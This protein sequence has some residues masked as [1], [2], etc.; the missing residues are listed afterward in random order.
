LS[1]VNSLPAEWLPLESAPL[2]AAYC[3]TAARVS[4]IERQLRKTKVRNLSEYERLT[5]LARDEG[6][7]MLRL[8][9]SLRL[10]PHTRMGARTAARRSGNGVP[11]AAVDFARLDEGDEA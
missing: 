6:S 8:A 3:R 4:D 11:G 2:L 9:R 5:R 10:T 1:T 7:L